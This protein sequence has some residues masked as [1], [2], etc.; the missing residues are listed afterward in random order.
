[1]KYFM[2]LSLLL[3]VIACQEAETSEAIPSDWVLLT[4][5]TG[6]TFEV[7]DSF[8]LETLQG[9]DTYVGKIASPSVEIFFDIGWL[10]GEYVSAEDDEVTCDFA[11][12]EYCY[13]TT[14]DQIRAT[15]AE[16]GPANFTSSKENEQLFLEIMGTFVNN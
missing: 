3:L 9:I 8:A 12:I 1:M 16:A 10:A 2:F 15:F 7:P 4:L 13:N 14:E 11:T 6:D 5:N